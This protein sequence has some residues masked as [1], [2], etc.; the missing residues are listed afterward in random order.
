MTEGA[1]HFIHFG[2][3][4]YL[5]LDEQSFLLFGFILGQLVEVIIDYFLNVDVTLTVLIFVVVGTLLHD[6]VEHGG[7]LFGQEGQGPGEDIET[8]WE[9]VWWL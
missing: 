9:A 3:R 7:D 8:V 5:T 2:H 6:G 4:L 1:K